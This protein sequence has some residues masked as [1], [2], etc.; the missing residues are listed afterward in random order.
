MS[1]VQEALE[2]LG[3]PHGALPGPSLLANLFVRFQAQVPLRRLSDGFGPE[4]ALA[5]WLED[6]A[7]CCGGS[8]VRAFE[9]LATAAG[10]ASAPA[11]GAKLLSATLEKADPDAIERDTERA[12][13][14]DEELQRA[15]DAGA[16]SGPASS[17]QPSGTD[18]G[19]AP[20]PR[21]G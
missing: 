14:T 2:A 5:A 12:R 4:E 10:F 1:A 20:E 21:E 7:G 19:D 13:P 18:P 6:G 8:R 3:H 11:L 17:R 9:A 16:I 15:G